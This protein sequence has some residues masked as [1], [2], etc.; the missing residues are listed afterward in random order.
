MWHCLCAPIVTTLII[1]CLFTN[2]L[3]R[4]KQLFT[5]FLACIIGLD[6]IS[7]QTLLKGKVSDNTGQGLIGVS[8]AEKGTT[9]GTVSGVDGSFNLRISTDGATLTFTYL[10]YETLTTV[11][12]GRTVI[13][14]VMEQSSATLDQIVIV[15][16]R[17]GS[18]VK[19][20]TPVPVDVITPAQVMMPS[21]KMDITSALNYAAPS[22]NYNKQT[23]SDGADHID[24]ATLRGLGPDQTL[25]LVNGK[26]RHQTAYV[27]VFGTRGRGNSGTDLNAISGAAIDRVEILRDGASAQYGSDAIA[28]VINI[29]TKNSVGKLSGNIGFSGYNDPDYNAANADDPSQYY[30][31]SKFDGQTLNAGLNYGFALGSK[32]GF[33]NLSA[34]FSTVGKTYRQSIDIEEIPY[35]NYV[36]RAFGDASMTG[37][38]AFLNMELPASEGSTFYAFGGANVKSSDAFAYTRNFSGR[39]ERFVTDANGNLLDPNNIV[40]EIAD[41]SDRFYNPHIQTEIQDYSGAVGLRGGNQGNW[42]WDLSNTTGYNN[43]HFFGDKTFNAS[44]G[45]ANKNNFDDGGYSFLQNTSN[46]SFSKE[47]AGIASGFNL[48]LGAEYR[49]ENYQLYAGE[50]ASWKSYNEDKAPG[51]QGFPGYQPGDEKDA[52]RN[53]I[54]AYVDAE[55]DI[56]EKWLLGGAVRAEYYSDFG[57]TGNGKLATRFKVSPNF[58]LRGSVST[59][60]RAP[61]LQQLNFSST[62]TTVQGGN[63]FEVKIAPNDNDITRSAGI[64]ELK[65]ERSVNASLGFTTRLAPGLSLTLDGYVVKVTDR[66]VLSGQFSASDASLNPVFTAKLQ[67]LNVSSAQFFANA[68]NTTNSGLDI[69]LEYNKRIGANQHFKALLAGNLQKMSIDQVNVPARLNNSPYFLS[70]RE[71]K[72]ILASAPNQKGT[73]N[74]EYGIGKFSIGTRLSLFGKI[75]LL[76]Y[77]EDGSGVDPMV[78]TDADA[79]VYV[80]DEYVYGAKVVNDWYLTY[81]LSKGIQVYIGADNIGNVHPDLAVVEAAKGWAFNCETGGPW[82]AVQM[83]GN[84]RRLF[85]RAVLNF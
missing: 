81:K 59:G 55:M 50:E 15:G 4:M 40:Q 24:L 60:F 9:N 56:T 77:G 16:S 65:Q 1:I 38:G 20:E 64:E 13:D 21:A 46:L 3:S 67:E 70:D 84:G 22:F 85:A 68:V 42:Q 36:R 6:L 76:G 8:I 52:T 31:G 18:R 34:D 78:P 10:G 47:I 48:A 28:G 73:L 37:G 83:G 75:V 44:L 41:G 79:N 23:G 11:V 27:S 35:P 12:D 72:F 5:L 7:A 17:R 69:V 14:V 49:F 43:F 51:A 26:R 63:I 33:L 25:V 57:F 2:L 62:F 82:D 74:L 71:E 39:P 66:V 29:I 32:G 58:N 30:T 61:S 45:D 53:V 80:K 54:G 19:S